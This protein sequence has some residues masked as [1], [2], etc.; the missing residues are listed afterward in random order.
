[1]F[2][3]KEINCDCKPEATLELNKLLT[4][5]GTWIAPFAL[6]YLLHITIADIEQNA[7]LFIPAETVLTVTTEYTM[8]S[9]YQAYIRLRDKTTNAIVKEIS[10]CATSI[11]EAK[12]YANDLRNCVWIMSPRSSK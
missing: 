11:S 1:M 10:K 3:P 9:P 7:L 8:S 2:A 5:G 12:Q 4:A 6:N